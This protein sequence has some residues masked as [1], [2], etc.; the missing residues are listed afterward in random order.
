MTESAIIFACLVIIAMILGAIIGD[1][2]ARYDF[3]KF[4]ELAEDIPDELHDLPEPKEADICEWIDQAPLIMMG[5][6][7]AAEHSCSECIYRTI[8]N[9]LDETICKQYGIVHSNKTRADAEEDD[10][11]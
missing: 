4:M 11:K 5:Y 6:A 10:K 2:L 9:R 3:K 7:Y 8:C 1:T